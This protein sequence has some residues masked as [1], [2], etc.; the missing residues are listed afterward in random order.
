[1]EQQAWRQEQQGHQFAGDTTRHRSPNHSFG[2][3]WKKAMLNISSQSGVSARLI[4]ESH[5]QIS[6]SIRVFAAQ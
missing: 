2:D 1:M 4:P 5:S 6:P 3:S